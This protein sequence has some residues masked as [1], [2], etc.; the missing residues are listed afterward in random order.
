VLKISLVK[1]RMLF[2]SV[3]KPLIVLRFFIYYFFFNVSVS[4]AAIVSAGGDYKA[5]LRFINI[6]NNKLFEI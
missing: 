6:S 3:N 1:Q 5:K 2:V 4:L